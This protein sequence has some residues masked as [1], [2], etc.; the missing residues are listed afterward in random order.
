MTSSTIQPETLRQISREHQRVL[1]TIRM[2]IQCVTYKLLLTLSTDDFDSDKTHKNC[3]IAALIFCNEGSKE[4]TPLNAGNT[5]I[6]ESNKTVIDALVSTAKTIPICMELQ[7]QSTEVTDYY[8]IL[9]LESLSVKSGITL[10]PRQE[11]DKHTIDR[12]KFSTIR[13]NKKAQLRSLI[14]EYRDRKAV[15]LHIKAQDI[16]T[17]LAIMSPF[18][19]V[20]GYLYDYYYLGYFGI[21]TSLFFTLSDYLA[22][23]IS[24]IRI[25][26]F[27]A[28]LSIFYGL[29]IYHTESL[30]TAEQRSSTIKSN[31]RLYAALLVFSTIVLII[32]GLI[33]RDAR[34]I[35]WIIY[36]WLTYFGSRNFVP[37]ILNRF[38]GRS[39]RAAMVVFF[40]YLYF[41]TFIAV[42]FNNQYTSKHDHVGGT[43]KT[44]FVM[45]TKLV[46]YNVLMANSNYVFFYNPSTEQT[47]VLP[48]AELL[49]ASTNNARGSN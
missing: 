20:S 8:N 39:F 10:P 38:V 25:C 37:F 24:N 32:G 43:F 17:I 19:L 5:L 49:S 29:L 7:K 2:I 27:T 22:S 1:A 6:Y 21:D 44:T 16:L 26:L 18:V 12:K 42:L 35:Y 41:I 34:A 3:H 33:Q 9:L 4:P 40:L 30:K 45:K 23:S 47:L 48:K 28:T 46:G 13:K 31:E 15:K 14:I 36:L 11:P